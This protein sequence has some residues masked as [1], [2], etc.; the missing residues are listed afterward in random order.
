MRNK[1][2]VKANKAI[3]F[4]SGKDAAKKAIILPKC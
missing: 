2:S 1:A 3:V 4:S